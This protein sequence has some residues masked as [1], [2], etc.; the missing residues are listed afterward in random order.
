MNR[1]SSRPYTR[2][3]LCSAGLVLIWGLATVPGRGQEVADRDETIKAERLESLREM[4]EMI[5]TLKV[6][7]IS[8]GDKLE[9]KHLAKP[10]LHYFDQPRKILDA[11]LWCIGDRGRPAAFCK[12]EKISV[13]D[14]NRWLYCFASLST[15]PIEA[16][17]G[18]G[19]TFST[20]GPGIRF[21]D[22]A[23][24]PA[25]ADAKGARLRQA[26]DLVRRI[27]VSLAD[28]DLAFKENLR[29]LSQPLHRY[30]DVQAGILDGAVFGFS[31]NGTCP[32]LLVLLEAQQ[33]KDGTAKWAMAA[34]RMTNCELHLRDQDREVWQ[35][36]FLRFADRI[37]ENLDTWMFFWAKDSR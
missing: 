34:A 23:G 10:L 9:A 37:G 4:K 7:T 17:W 21:T 33:G 28:P 29:L 18:E 13:A 14:R 12:I 8:H 19:K 11:T 26:K 15:V 24:A 2:S 3:I 16:E 27:N 35:A 20:T 1:R 32:D 5:G 22:L 31:T 6:A 30:E 25:P 36:P